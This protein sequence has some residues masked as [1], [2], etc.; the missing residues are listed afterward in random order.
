MIASLQYVSKILDVEGLIPNRN[1]GQNFFIN[2]TLLAALIENIPLQDKTIIEIGPGLGSLTEILLNR[3]ASVT[4]IEKD[5]NMVRLLQA[6][7]PTPLL[8]VVEADCLRFSFDAIKKPFTVA[9][10]LPY[11]IT[12][13]ILE[14]LLKIHPEQMVLMLQKEAADRFF[15]KPSDKNYMP[16]NAVLSL[17]YSIDKLGEIGPENYYPSPN[18]IST[19]LYLKE[20]SDLPA[21]SPSVLLAFV[22]ECFRMRRKTLVNNLANY[23]GVKALLTDIGLPVSVRGEALS[24]EELLSLFHVLMHK[25]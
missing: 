7:L 15:A 3:G 10:N 8:T 25:D 22:K 20:R 24:P 17:Y 12:A 2:G 18:V 9:G 11:Y 21:D 5:P 19:M 6:A 14:M 13:D 1:L 4:A 23:Q 16:L